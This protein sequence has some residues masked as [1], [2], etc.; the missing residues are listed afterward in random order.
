MSVS[1]I[2]NGSLSVAHYESL[3]AA[4]LNH[5][6]MSVHGMGAVL[7]EISG[8]EGAGTR[9]DRVV[10][11]LGENGY[12]WRMNMT[13]QRAN[14]T[15]I[16]DIA[17][18]CIENGCRHIIS[19][20]FLPHYEWNDPAKLRQ[21]AVHPAELRTYIEQVGE[22]VEQANAS[23]KEIMFTIR[24]HPMCHLAERW[25]KYVVNAAYVLY[26]PW[27]WDYGHRGEPD[28]AFWRSAIQMGGSV[29]INENPCSVCEAFIHCGGWNRVYC[30][31][32]GKPPEI[33][34]AITMPPNT[35]CRGWLH[36]LNPAN[37]GKGWF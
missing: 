33:L 14:Y 7:D 16:P 25:R 15:T 3:Y 30:N 22:R 11:W 1:I 26:D 9:Q 21:V 12:P 13:V 2:S 17:D 19:L 29:S 4:G 18:F 36:L 10:K 35:A 6:H 20:G 31:G 34:K 5:I 37:S 8:V 28:H 24:Y 27:E 23:G 32:F